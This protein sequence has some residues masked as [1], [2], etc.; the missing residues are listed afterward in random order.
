MQ[1]LEL[2]V[3]VVEPPTLAVYFPKLLGFSPTRIFG[4][5]VLTSTVEVASASITGAPVN[6]LILV[7]GGAG[8]EI[9]KSIVEPASV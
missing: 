3:T 6:P 8:T 4:D 7:T 5:A 9:F 1:L 2:I